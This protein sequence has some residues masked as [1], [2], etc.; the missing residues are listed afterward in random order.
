[1]SHA[2]SNTA[3][4]AGRRRSRVRIADVAAALGLT[5]G[6]VSRALNGYPDISDSTRLRVKRKAEVMGYR[7][8]SQAQT[9]RTGRARSI[10]LVL[11]ADVHDA[12]RP[13][14]SEFLAGLTQ[15]TSDLNW[16]LT[17]A[18]AHGNQDMRETYDRLLDER[19]ADGFIIPRTLLDDPRIDH[20]REAEVPFV[21]FG[22]T[23]NPE[24]CAWFDIRGE[25]AMAEAVRRLHD[26][27]HR[28]IG[29]VG[30][31]PEH[32]FSLLRLDGYRRSLAAVG[33]EPDESIVRDHAVTREDGAVAA[34]ALMFAE[35]PPTAIV[36]AVDMA[37]IGAYNALRR[38]DLRIGQD[39]SI[40]SY[41]GIPEAAYCDPPLTTF[42]VDTRAAGVRLATMLID[43]IR[44]TAPEDLRETVA[45]QICTGGSDG[46][47]ARTSEEIA[48][49]VREKL[50]T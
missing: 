18:T 38:L 40:V 48:R 6:T 2:Q 35:K 39:V 10:G 23:R 27:G 9:I 29:F 45:A 3:A 50:E 22:R 36:F 46:P 25:D 14:L 34:Q 42:G 15:A 21:L 5:K 43:R 32:T 44:G 41:D 4:A 37:A 20:L 11:Q 13:F 49:H 17:V 7:P 1:M 28:R 24:G 12:H 8:L 30:A 19:K 47:P 33:L 16:T 31:A 26:F